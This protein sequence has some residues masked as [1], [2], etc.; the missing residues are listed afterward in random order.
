MT[1]LHRPSYRYEDPTLTAPT[2][3]RA[4]IEAVGMVE[5]V[6]GVGPKTGGGYI[7]VPLAIG[8]LHTRLLRPYD[9][10]EMTLPNTDV[11]LWNSPFIVAGHAH[12]CFDLAERPGWHWLRWT[13]AD[14]V[15]HDIA[16]ARGAT[17]LVIIPCG[18][19]KIRTAA[20]AGELYR[21][22]YFRL[23]LRAAS[24][25][26]GPESI[27]ILSARHGLLPL[28][29]VVAP[30]DL[31]LGQPGAVA[32]PELRDQ[33]AEQSLLDRPDVVL[34]GGRDY[35]EL[36]QQVWPHA[37]I[38]LAGAAGIGEQQQRLAAIAT[39]GHLN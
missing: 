38:P 30:Y 33:A 10:V 3:G 36:A 35:V 31:R 1:S 28:H 11:R 32:A 4:L 21:G 19:S 26:T 14:H 2:P 34:F 9:G 17:P 8:P 5:S 6:A 24:A 27:R 29:R 12:G 25:L 7:G 22:T 18:G 23:G 15:A 16:Q 20:P 37:R 39:A 13:I